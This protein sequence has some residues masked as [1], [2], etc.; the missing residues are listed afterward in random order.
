MVDGVLQHARNGAVVFGR[1]EQQA[2]RGCHLGL[3]PQHG[4]GLLPIVVL[5]I[6]R[7]VADADFGEGKIGR[8]QAGERMGELAVDGVLAQA[9]DEECDLVAIHGDSFPGFMQ[10]GW[11][12]LRLYAAARSFHHRRPLRRHS[13]Y[14]KPFR[15]A[16]NSNIL[17]IGKGYS[18]SRQP[19]SPAHPRH[20]GRTLA[21]RSYST[22]LCGRPLSQAARRLRMKKNPA[23]GAAGFSVS[24]PRS[25]RVAP[26]TED[27]SV[28]PKGPSL[29][30][31][32]MLSAA[33]ASF[34]PPRR[35]GLGC[36]A[37]A[38]QSA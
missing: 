2:L 25:G 23:A 14:R 32:T 20:G 24:C 22:R 6:E 38:T 15:Y 36:G 19:P 11:R 9:S 29:P 35:P 16:F 34:L 12:R 10:S 4:R 13:A 21:A 26:R 1:H 3:E 5:V 18:S 17:T 30:T 8:R 33:G 28:R 31:C 7:Q 37:S 27:Q